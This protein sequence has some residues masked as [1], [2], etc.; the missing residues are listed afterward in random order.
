MNKTIKCKQAKMLIY[1]E[2]YRKSNDNLMGSILTKAVSF[3]K[4]LPDVPCGRCWDVYQRRRNVLP[5]GWLTKEEEKRQNLRNVPLRNPGGLTFWF[6]LSL[7]GSR[8]MIPGA[9]Q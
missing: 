8:Q 9:G 1:A 6:S 3:T 4:L 5:R 2:E 7:C